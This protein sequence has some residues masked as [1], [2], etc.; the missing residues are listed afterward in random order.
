MDLGWKRIFVRIHDDDD[1][2]LQARLRK[3]LVTAIETRQIA[4]GSRL[5][6]SR[7]LALLLAISRNTVLLAY[8]QL[9]DEGYLV[10]RQR[11]GIFVGA[12]D[13]ARLAPESP[14]APADESGP[15]WNRLFAVRPT[16]FRHISKPRNHEAYPYS[17]LFGQ[18]DPSLFPIREWRE[19]ARTTS[20]VSGIGLWAGDMVDEDD[21]GLIEQLRAQVLPRRGIWAAE[22]EVMVTLGAQQALYLVIRLLTGPDTVFGL[23]D[24]GYPDSRHMAQLQ[25][26]HLRLLHL[27]AE[28]VVPDE[29]LAGCDVALTTPGHQ[30]PTTV[31][32]SEARRRDVL[33]LAARRDIVLIE[34]DYDSDLL[35]DGSSIASLKSMDGEGRVIHVGSLSKVL[36]PGLRI[37]YV[38]APAPVIA[39]LRVLR[40]IM[41]RHPPHNNQRTMASFI[42]LGHYRTHLRRIGAVLQ[43]R[44]TL[45]D[46]LLPDCLPQ[47][48][49]GRAPGA[50]S[51][52]IRCP[53]QL[54]SA[55]LAAAA[56]AEGVLIEPGG[57]FY[58]SPEHGRHCLRL[59]FSSIR[60][61]R[62][63]AGL[64]RLGAVMNRIAAA[65]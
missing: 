10:S 21:P 35:N 38:V 56:R 4:Q 29:A 19:S 23:E 22:D 49:S 26:K 2:T 41:L 44:A 20:S 36:A 12:T 60:E 64:A 1:A 6:S 40:R 55:S 28:G 5:P 27:D 42:A 53:P 31:I 48:R 61:S 13:R 50:G 57:V 37:G 7:K 45:I 34:D 63:E 43:R 15:D 59:G 65:A 25:T 46:G 58:A 54:D 47:C 16:A 3:A 18:P 52:W 14:P 17:F 39:E 62:I 33:A 51:F 32:M 24:P 11:S 30:C 8:Q 9:A